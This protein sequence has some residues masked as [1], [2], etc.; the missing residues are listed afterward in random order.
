M[1]ARSQPNPLS[2]SVDDYL[3]AI[4]ALGGSEEKRATSTALAGRLGVAPASVTN[5]LQKLSTYPRHWS[6]ISAITACC[7]HR[8]ESGALWKSCGIIG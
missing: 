4:L 5:M 1:A 2:E 6:S 8:R 7:F 3:K